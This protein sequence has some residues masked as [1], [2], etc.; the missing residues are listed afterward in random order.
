MLFHL[1]FPLNPG[2]ITIK[3]DDGRVIG[4][5]IMCCICTDKLKILKYNNIN[6]VYSLFGNISS[7]TMSKCDSTIKA[8][9][10]GDPAVHGGL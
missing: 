6:I 5:Y 3:Y 4:C 9:F 7:F 8:V 10:T 1:G 2:V